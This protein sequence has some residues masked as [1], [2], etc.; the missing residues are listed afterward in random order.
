VYGFGEPT[1]D[2]VHVS[3][4]AR[5]FVLAAEGRRAGTFNVGT[6]VETSVRRLLD[7]LA[8]AAGGAEDPELQPLR[9]GELE[10]SALDS[11]L[12]ERE[13]GWRAE[14]PLERGLAETYRT[15]APV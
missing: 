4:V 9:P 15:Y 3:D 14:I 10:R 5:A 7:L 12:I 1:R 6:G 11:T 13:L 8:D 2:Y